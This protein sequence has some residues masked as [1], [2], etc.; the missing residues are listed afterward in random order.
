MPHAQD[1]PGPP[2]SPRAKRRRS[3]ACDL[4]CRQ[5]QHDLNGRNSVHFPFTRFRE[6]Q[7]R[8]TTWRISLGESI[9]LVRVTISR[10]DSHHSQRCCCPLM[11]SRK[12]VLLS[13]TCFGA[14]RAVVS[15]NIG[16]CPEHVHSRNAGHGSSSIADGDDGYDG[17]AARF[18]SFAIEFVLPSLAS[19]NCA[20]SGEG[21]GRRRN[22]VSAHGFEC[23]GSV[24]ARSETKSLRR[25]SIGKRSRAGPP[26]CFSDLIPLLQ[27]TTSV[28]IECPLLRQQH[29]A[30]PPVHLEEI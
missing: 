27:P 7:Y 13:Q 25:H 11:C 10:C 26:L 23:W 20:S 21:I 4:D 19:R 28:W 16:R 3:S 9:G 12:N 17:G 15:R 24:F 18:H 5:L 30:G 14:S 2:P 8:Q 22:H 29:F 6:W 1:K